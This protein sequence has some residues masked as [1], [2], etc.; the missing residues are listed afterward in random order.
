MGRKGRGAGRMAGGARVTGRAPG[1]R[2]A[3]GGRQGPGG[4][5]RGSG[6]S[7]ARLARDVSRADPRGE[8]LGLAS[9][10][11]LDRTGASPD[12]DRRIGGVAAGTRRP[13]ARPAMRGVVV[14]AALL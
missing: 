14:R 4:T 1:G 7:G 6:Q 8:A 9:T 5:D 2:R 13:L 11:G 3:A 12:T 10:A